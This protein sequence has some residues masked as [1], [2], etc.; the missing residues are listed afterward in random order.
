MAEDGDMLDTI[1]SGDYLELMDIVTYHAVFADPELEY[2]TLSVHTDMLPYKY[3]GTHIN[4]LG[5]TL[6]TTRMIDDCQ[7]LVQLHVVESENELRVEDLKRDTTGCILDGLCF[8]DTILRKKGYYIDTVYSADTLAQIIKWNVKFVDETSEVIDTI[9][10]SKTQMEKPYIYKK[11]FEI[12]HLCDT[13]LIDT[14]GSCMKYIKLNVQPRYIYIDVDTAVCQGKSITIGDTTFYK[15]TTYNVYN[16]INKYTEEVTRWH[17]KFNKP[18]ETVEEQVTI[19]EGELPYQ[20]GDSLLTEA[21]VYDLILH[22]DGECDKILKLTLEVTDAL[23]NTEAVQ[24]AV[25]PTIIH[26][27]EYITVTVS[28]QT[29]FV[30]TDS[31]GKKVESRRL[32][33]GRYSI[34]LIES[35]LYIA[36]MSTDS[37]TTTTKKILVK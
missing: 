25:E 22:E 4:S 18:T 14:I 23:D 33:T 31:Q 34:R 13:I 35:G 37:G 19:A 3:Y 16:R 21:G 24:W 7:R 11:K 36:T 2:D 32:D 28:G 26:A 6:V 8:G 5:D 17:L 29:Y 27:G 15:K 1:Y 10:L 12:D 30:L 9:A 20:Y